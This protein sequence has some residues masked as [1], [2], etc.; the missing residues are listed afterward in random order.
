[1]AQKSASS[2]K[3]CGRRFLPLPRT[4]YRWRK[5]T[6]WEFGPGPQRVVPINEGGRRRVGRVASSGFGAYLSV[7]PQFSR[8]GPLSR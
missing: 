3:F 5:T 6:R 7:D 8:P 1:M 4:T 2:P